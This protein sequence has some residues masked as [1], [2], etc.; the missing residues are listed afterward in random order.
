MLSR[1]W[2]PDFPVPVGVLRRVERPTHDALLRGQLDAAVA[3]SGEGDL[4]AA[5]M[6]GE[7]WTVK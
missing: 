1:L 7:T 6:A 2:W 3:K 4:T 5:L